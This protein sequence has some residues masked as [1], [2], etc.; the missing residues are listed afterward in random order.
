MDLKSASTFQNGPALD[1]DKS[2]SILLGTRQRSH[3]YIA[4]SSINVSD[5]T[6][7]LIDHVKLLDVTLDSLLTFDKH[8]NL[9]S[10][11]CFYHIRALRHIVQQSTRI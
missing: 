10:K 5:A 3:S 11:A 8:L 7:P 9:L 2:E 4:V 1:A 6:V